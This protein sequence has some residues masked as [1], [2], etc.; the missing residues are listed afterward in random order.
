MRNGRFSKAFEPNKRRKQHGSYDLLMHPLYLTREKSIRR[1]VWVKV[2]LFINLYGSCRLYSGMTACA[3]RSK[4]DRIGGELAPPPPWHQAASSQ[5]SVWAQ[6]RSRLLF[7]NIAATIRTAVH[8]VA[9]PHTTTHMASNIAAS[10]HT[11]THTASNIAA[12]AQTTMPTSDHIVSPSQPHPTVPTSTDTSTA[13]FHTPSL[14]LSLLPF[15]LI[16]VLRC[17]RLYTSRLVSNRSAWCSYS[18]YPHFCTRACRSPTML[19]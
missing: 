10:A 14:W 4:H 8:I 1:L 2:E 7:T 12:S 9:P 11:A 5:A 13:N 19:S 17:V 6:P 16:C 3:A 18:P 15:K